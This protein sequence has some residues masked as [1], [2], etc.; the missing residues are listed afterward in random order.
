[1]TVNFT[2]VVYIVQRWKKLTT[3]ILLPERVPAHWPDAAHLC[4]AGRKHH[5]EQTT[6]LKEFTDI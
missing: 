4:S 3:P 5:G 1:M 2:D 6:T